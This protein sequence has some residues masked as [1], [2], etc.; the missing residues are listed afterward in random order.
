MTRNPIPK[1]RKQ[2]RSKGVDSAFVE[3]AGGRRYLGPYGSPESR[4]AYARVIAEWSAGG[5]MA[6]VTPSEI[7]TTELVARYWEY[8]E[9]YYRGKEGKPSK[10]LSKIRVATRVLIRLY[11]SLPACAFGP[12]RLKTCRQAFID[13]G[14]CRSMVNEQVFRIKRIFKWCASE[15]LISES[16]YRSLQTVSSLRRGRSAARETEPVRPVPDEYVDAIE[17]YVLG[18]IWAAIQ[19]QRLTGMRPTELLSMRGCDLNMDGDLWIYTPR[20]HKSAH[21]GFTRVIEIGPR[22]QEVLGP[23]LKA[24][25][26]AHLFSPLDA[27]AERAARYPT[28]RRPDQVANPRKTSRRVRDNYDAD[29]YRKAVQRAC[30]LA[31]VPVWTP[32]QLRHNYATVVRRK[33]GIELARVLLKHRS[34]V[35]SELYAEIDRGKAREVVAKIG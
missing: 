4:E 10:E 7:T 9:G 11:G 24:D 27:V 6:P 31:G 20:T 1:Y 16:V 3:L 17:P 29:G 12:L 23:L 30:K 8:A 22:A 32:H 18:P 21:H 34:A 19:V 2:K 25:L 33:Y 14:N 28:H 15:E 35:T 5:G 26:A 13:A